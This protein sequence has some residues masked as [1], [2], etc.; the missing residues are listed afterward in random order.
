MRN[1]TRSELQ[2]IVGEHSDLSRNAVHQLNY[3]MNKVD[4]V[5]QSRDCSAAARND[6]AFAQ[7]EFYDAFKNLKVS[8]ETMELLLQSEYLAS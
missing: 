2:R 6:E 5:V 1:R 3:W 8:V 4:V 7:Q